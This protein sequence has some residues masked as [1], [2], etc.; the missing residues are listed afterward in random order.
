MI[1]GINESKADICMVVGN[2]HDVKE[3]LALGIKLPQ[4]SVDSFQSLGTQPNTD[5]CSGKG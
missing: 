3:L 2:E 4:L 1:D 5:L